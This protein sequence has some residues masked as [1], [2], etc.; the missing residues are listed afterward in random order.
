MKT[1]RTEIRRAKYAALISGGVSANLAG[2]LKD[3][4]EKKIEKIVKITKL[5]DSDYFDNLKIITGRDYR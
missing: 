3:L 5:R 4:S 1:P 2:K